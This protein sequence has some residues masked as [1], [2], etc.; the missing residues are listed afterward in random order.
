M[1]NKLLTG[2]LSVGIALVLWLYVVTVVSPNS[3]NHYYNI[4]VNIQGEAVLQDRGL[5]ITSGQL[6]AVS[7]HLEGNRTDLNKINS[8]N[9]S[10]GVDVSG[11]GEPGTYHLSL[12]S[13]NFLTDVP[14]T[15]INVLS[16]DPGTVTVQ[17]DYRSSKPVPVDIRYSGALPENFMADKDGR[18]L[19]F[20]N[21]TIT[22]P[23]TV[24]DQIAMARI[25]VNLDGREE[26]L[27]QQYQY[28]LCNAK[29]EP[30]D[31]ELVVTDV[32]AVN[33]TLK[34]VRVKE[35]ALTVAVVYG[36]GATEETAKVTVE[37]GT[38]LVSGSDALL[39]NLTQI[40]IGTINLQDIAADETQI[41]PIKLP[42]G[43][44]NETGMTEAKVQIAFPKLGLKEL[45]IRNIQAINVPQGMEVQLITQQLELT[46]RGPLGII[47][48]VTEEN[49]TVTVDFGQEQIGTASVKAQI[50]VNIE[51][52][53]AVGTYNVTATVK[54]K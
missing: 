23:K 25:D 31:A 9:I 6:P 42:E 20:E 49:V 17:V 29:G 33:L 5:M 48:S 40:E 7:L 50:T 1:K 51:G 44:T 26:S 36:G 54:K 52:V 53:G 10:I 14:N 24:I 16:K 13:P 19:D 32:E 34:I 38:I 21:V 27:S 46:L 2:L 41:L 11:I 12:T 39:E 18:I 22:G 15:A 30:V 37:P 4:P 35:V 3:D 43:I 28:T 45:T 8:S 47:E